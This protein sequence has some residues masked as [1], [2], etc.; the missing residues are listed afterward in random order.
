MQC[1]RC[2]SG[3]TRRDGR[4]RRGGQ[5]WRCGACRRRF[6]ARSASAFSGHRFPDDVIALAVRWYA[7]YRLSCA[8]VAEWL[9]ERGRTVD[10]TAIYRWVQ[11]ACPD[12]H[13]SQIGAAFGLR[14]IEARGR[15]IALNGERLYLDGILYQPATATFAEMRRHLYAVQKLGCNLVRARIAGIDPRVYQLADELGVL[16]WVEV[17]SPHRSSVRSRE[18]HRNE[19]RRLLVHIGSHPSVAILS[20]D[21]G[22]WG[23]EDIATNPETR[24]T[25]PARWPTC[26]GTSR[27]CWS[28]TTTAGSTSRPKGAWSPTC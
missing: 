4:T 17:P 25:S 3:T 10:R 13:V 24:R 15:W 11:L 12:G 6:T 7:R 18:K 16:L 28:W 19:L 26:A 23:A 2:G 9:A 5:R 21:N 20:L 1:G 8:D 22:V 27:S 14:R